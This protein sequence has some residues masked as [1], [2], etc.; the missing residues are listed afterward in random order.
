MT[1]EKFDDLIACH[2]VRKTLHLERG[3]GRSLVASSSGSLG[4]IVHH[5]LVVWGVEHHV[6]RLVGFLGSLGLSWVGFDHFVDQ[7][8]LFLL[9]TDL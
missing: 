7:V 5:C 2:G 8:V 6:L 4:T 3:H 9:I 1:I